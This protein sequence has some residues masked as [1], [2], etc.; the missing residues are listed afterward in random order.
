MIDITAMQ[1]E[2]L[3]FYN[4]DL[5]YKIFKNSPT[6]DQDVKDK[7]GDLWENILKNGLTGISPASTTVTTA[8]ET[9]GTWLRNNPALGDGGTAFYAQFASAMSTIINGMSGYS[10]VS[11]P[12]PLVL[13]A[14]FED[15]DLASSTL[16]GQ[17]KSCVETGV[18]SNI[19]TGIPENLS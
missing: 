6:L 15:Y 13:N 1:D 3:K 2:L 7:V 4:E 8:A 19:S 18:V 11:Q 16:A 9:L 17:I 10:P 14:P 12:I 5:E